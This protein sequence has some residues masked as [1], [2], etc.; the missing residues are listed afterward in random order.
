MRGTR[1]TLGRLEVAGRTLEGVDALVLEGLGTNL[2]G[3]S[4]LGRLGAVE[5]RGGTMVLR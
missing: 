5:M 1:V 4:V 3:Q 2:L